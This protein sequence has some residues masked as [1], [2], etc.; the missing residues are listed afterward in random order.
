M[1]YQ[2]T[3]RI[4]EAIHNFALDRKRHLLKGLFVRGGFSDY[5]GNKAMSLPILETGLVFTKDGR[6]TDC[7]EICVSISSCL[8]NYNDV[9]SGYPLN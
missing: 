7:I 3:I 8:D 4:T 1:F 2:L 9:S 5:I 6:H